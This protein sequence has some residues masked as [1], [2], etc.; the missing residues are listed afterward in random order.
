MTDPWG[1]F[2]FPWSG[3][4]MVL[5]DGESRPHVYEEKTVLIG[6]SGSTVGRGYGLALGRAVFIA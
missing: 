4:A 3:L 6:W 1:I 5:D 2:L